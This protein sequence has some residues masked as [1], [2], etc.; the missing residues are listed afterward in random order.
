MIIEW[1]ERTKRKH[2][3]KVHFESDSFQMKDSI[4]APVHLIPENIHDNQEFDFY[5]KTKYDVYLLRIINNKDN[6]GI[7]CPTKVNEIIYIVSYIP[8][9]KNSIIA[10]IREILNELEK[11]GFPNLRHTES[12]TIFQISD[13]TLN[14]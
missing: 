11:Y 4:V 12:K 2:N 5:I 1:I 7:I 13:I 14:Y 8:V 6:Y 10:S 9:S 3:C